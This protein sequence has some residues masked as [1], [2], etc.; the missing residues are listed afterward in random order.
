MAAFE[1]MASLLTPPR[2]SCLVDVANRVL[3]ALWSRGWLADPALNEASLIE[4]AQRRTGLSDLGD[5]WFRQPLRVLLDALRHEAA[6]NALG[7]FVAVGQLAKLLRER[8]WTQYW[9]DARPDILK[10]RLKRPVIVIGPMRSGTTRLHRLLAADTR[11]SHMRFFETVCPVPPPVFTPGEKDPRPIQAGRILKAVRHANPRTA[12]IHP[13]GPFE[14]EEELGLLV[15][16]AWG[17]KHEVQWRIPSYGGWSEAQD[18]TPAYAHMARLLRIVGWARADCDDRPWVLKT[19]QH[20]LDLPALL[21]VFPDARLIFIHRDPVSVVGS[22]CSLAWNQMIIHSDVADA[23]HVGRTWLRKTGLQ[24]DRMRHARR[25]I[26]ANRMIDVQYD[27]METDWEQVMQRIYGFLDM[28]IAPALPAMRR[29]FTVSERRRQVHAYSLGAFGLEEHEVRAQ[30]RSYIHDFDLGR[31]DQAH[32]SERGRRP[33]LP[34]R[35]RMGA[36]C[37]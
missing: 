9:L 37:R 8:L 32:D 36:A 28:D 4:A 12:A 30:F 34:Q 27:E 5:P 1:T 11:F 24:I 22:S 31:P 13:T 2:R 23:G 33:L 16:S 14:P 3:P 35:R 26:P 7:H 15:A 17:M 20:M 21:A 18:A 25:S 6:L 19:P 29:Y 10:R